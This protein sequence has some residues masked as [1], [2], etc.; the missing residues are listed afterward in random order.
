[1]PV[2][3]PVVVSSRIGLPAMNLPPMR[4]LVRRYRVMCTQRN[5]LAISCM[6]PCPREPPLVVAS[7]TTDRRWANC[8]CV[9]SRHLRL[10][11]DP[12]TLAGPSG[13]GR[14]GCAVRRP[15][16][17]LARGWGRAVESVDVA[18]MPVRQAGWLASV[19][20]SRAGWWGR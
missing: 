17:V 9:L 1:L 8:C 15:V 10:F 7:L 3:R 13:L 12:S 6:P 19:R 11:L 20:R 4:P 16:V 2:R 5:A 18:E 14:L